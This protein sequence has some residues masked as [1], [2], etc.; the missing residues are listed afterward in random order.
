MTPAPGSSKSDWRDHFRARL[1]HLQSA[2]R[3]A[4]SALIRQRLEAQPEWQRA[5]AVLLF[6]PMTDEPDILPLAQ[7]VLSSDKT[8]A[9]PRHSSATDSYEA[10]CVTDLA[11]DLA[12]GRFGIAE[13]RPECPVCPWNELDFCLVPG[14][15]FALD[16]GRVGRGRGYFDRILA[17]V[18]GF[19]CGVAF[20]CQVVPELPAEP[21]DV[22]V[23]CIL[24]PTRWHLTASRARS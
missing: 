14:V 21:H 11:H 7:A 23:D 1:S 24:T 12:P 8:L 16:G 5:R 15:G 2:D 18:R 22:R 9:F 19:K 13:P 17:A 3:A 4:A 20:D 6:V 10:A